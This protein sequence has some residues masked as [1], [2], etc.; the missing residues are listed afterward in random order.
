[1]LVVDAAGT[2]GT[3]GVGDKGDDGATVAPPP[4]L[5]GSAFWQDVA[6]VRCM[7]VSQ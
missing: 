1:M 7:C 5:A 4:A 3:G 2:G 6:R